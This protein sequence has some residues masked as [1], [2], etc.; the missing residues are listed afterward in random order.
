MSTDAPHPV[1]ASPS[2]RGQEEVLSRLRRGARAERRW[3]SATLSVGLA[4]L[5][6][7][8]VL[9]IAA[10][11]IAPYGPTSL[12]LLH[13]LGPPSL[14]HLMGTDAFG[15]DVLSRVL[16][17]LRLDLQVTFVITYAPLVVGVV[18]GAFAG[19]FG[20]WLDTLVMR[21]IDAVVAF[22][23][24]VLVIAIVAIA[25]TGLTGVYIAVPVVS[26]ALYARLT[27]GEML[28]LREQDFIQAAK[29]L[30]YSTRRIIFRHALPT[31]LRS[32]LV[33]SAADLVLNLLL[34]ASLSYLGLGVQPPTSEL[35]V[36]VADGQ[37]VL[38]QAW[39]VA[40]LPGLTIVLLGVSFSMI[41]DGL[42]DRLGRQFRLA[43]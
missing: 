40:T 19:W 18:I 34:L 10:P 26:W 12:D 33:F 4:I 7:M 30:G 38:L 29:V 15:R 5:G 32:N 14:Q 11:L 1:E 43:L 17:A 13:R 23:F 16:T 37:S 36:M 28:V 6:L 22:P 27:R 39:W 8:L 41:G 3:S 35:G 24:L 9:G 21:L 20:G 25:G 31:L 2:E 42:A